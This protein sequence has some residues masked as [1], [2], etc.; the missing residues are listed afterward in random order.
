[1]NRKM[2]QMLFEIISAVNQCTQSSGDMMGCVKGI[3]ERVDIE[4]KVVSE[5]VDDNISIKFC[6]QNTL[7]SYIDNFTA[8]G[9]WMHDICMCGSTYPVIHMMDVRTI[10]S[11]ESMVFRN[12]LQACKNESSALKIA[13]V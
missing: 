8:M 5:L 7:I 9:V 6:V 13:Y 11:R 3:E 1:M 4:S 2:W 12:S 10:M